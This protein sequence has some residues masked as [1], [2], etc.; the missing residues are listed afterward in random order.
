VLE[1]FYCKRPPFFFINLDV[2]SRRLNSNLQRAYT[3]ERS[4]SIVVY[5]QSCLTDLFIVQYGQT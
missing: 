4:I 3:I 2:I 5:T 1:G